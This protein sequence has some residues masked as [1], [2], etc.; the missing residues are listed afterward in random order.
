MRKEVQ[1]R[2][3]D[4]RDVETGSQRFHLPPSIF[5]L[6]S[7]AFSLVEVTIA[8]GIAAFCLISMLGL[9]PGGMRN[10]A[11]ATEQTATIGILG[12][13]LSD[14]KGT[15]T[16]STNSPR[17]AITI[18]ASGSSASQ[19][20]YFTEDGHKVPSASSARYAVVANL[21]APTGSTV[22]NAQVRIYWPAAAST[23]N[24]SGSIES[25]TV[26]DRF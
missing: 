2:G 7:G 21:S 25:V 8:L 26:L 19:T 14:L 6:S 10:A 1:K 15:P 18:P 16:S 24:A 23:T 9:L 20:L 13:V 17:F 12:A 4:Q 22:A 5:L 3:T 11:T